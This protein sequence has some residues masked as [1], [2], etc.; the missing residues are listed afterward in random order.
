MWAIHVSGDALELRL[1]Q[2]YRIEMRGVS[3]SLLLK[4]PNARVFVHDP[5]MGTCMSVY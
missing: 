1:C 3:L 2:G 4:M 5:L